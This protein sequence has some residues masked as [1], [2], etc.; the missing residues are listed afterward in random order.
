[1]KSEWLQYEVLELIGSISMDSY[2]KTRFIWMSDIGSHGLM[3]LG[4]LKQ[5]QQQL[6]IF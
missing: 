5:V 3:F 6:N 4:Q 2:K 1:M